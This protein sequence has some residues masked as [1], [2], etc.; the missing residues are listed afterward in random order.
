[1]NSADGALIGGLLVVLLEQVGI[2]DLNGELGDRVGSTVSYKNMSGIF[3]QEGHHQVR[4]EGLRATS[5]HGK[6]V[7][8]VLLAGSETLEHFLL[9]LLLLLIELLLGRL[10]LLTIALAFALTTEGWT[11]SSS[12]RLRGGRL[13][14]VIGIL[15]FDKLHAPL[16]IGFVGL[17]VGHFVLTRI[18]VA[19]LGVLLGLLRDTNSM[20]KRVWVGHACV[21]LEGVV[22]CAMRSNRTFR[23]GRLLF[24]LSSSSSG[25]RGRLS[26]RVRFGLLLWGIVDHRVRR[27]RGWFRGHLLRRVFT[28]VHTKES[29]EM[30]GGV[31]EPKRA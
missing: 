14:C 19:A 17:D 10:S 23:A 11:T 8:L 28:G 15:L 31:K 20:F 9:L 13:I 30:G 22:V 6:L 7:G 27:T 4:G 1:M 18:R 2:G 12:I 3:E 5:F 21:V 24:T 29:Q 25:R 16:A 26:G